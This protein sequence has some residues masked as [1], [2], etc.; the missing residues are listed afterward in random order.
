MR[1]WW[2]WKYLCG[3]AWKARD[4]L[5]DFRHDIGSI[6]I[7]A[8][9]LRLGQQIRLTRKEVAAF[10]RIT[11]IEPAGI[12]TL[13]DLEAYVAKCKQHYWGVSE[14]TQFIHWLID[15]EYRQCHQAA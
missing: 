15:R 13:N 9:P 3:A 1:P 12:R 2:C 11:D 8:P 10:T 5:P 7:G 6:P 4:C 14:Q